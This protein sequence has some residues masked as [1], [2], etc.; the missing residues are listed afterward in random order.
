MEITEEMALAAQEARES[1][2]YRLLP[3][4]EPLEVECTCGWVGPYAIKWRA[5]RESE[6][7]KVALAPVL[8]AL[9]EAKRKLSDV[10]WGID[11]DRG[12]KT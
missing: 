10:Q 12:M 6:G 7:L 9:A 11:Y 1:H 3:F 4:T 8:E 5:H 2:R